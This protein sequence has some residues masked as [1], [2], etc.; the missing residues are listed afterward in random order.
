MF[1]LRCS[2]KSKKFNFNPFDYSSINKTEFGVVEE[3]EPPLLDHVELENILYEEGA[4][5]IEE[6]TFSY[7]QGG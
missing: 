3:E 4:Y 2:V 7:A 1:I 6:R 5:P